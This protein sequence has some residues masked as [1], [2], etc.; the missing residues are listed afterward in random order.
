MTLK[1]VAASVGLAPSFQKPTFYLVAFLVLG[2][3]CS[4]APLVYLYECLA[5]AVSKGITGEGYQEDEETLRQG[6][7]PRGTPS[8]SDLSLVAS[9]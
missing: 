4:V 8:A 9:V 1:V 7:D 5:R 2:F 6:H 3:V